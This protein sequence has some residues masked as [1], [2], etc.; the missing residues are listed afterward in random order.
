MILTAKNG[1]RMK[2]NLSIVRA[3]PP[4]P[5]HSTKEK[6]SVMIMINLEEASHVHESTQQ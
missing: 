6:A 2:S 4:T 5:T 3:L 1:A